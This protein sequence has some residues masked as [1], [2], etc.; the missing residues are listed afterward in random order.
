M[1]SDIAGLALGPL[2]VVEKLIIGYKISLWFQ[3]M[4]LLQIL[5]RFCDG[6]SIQIIWY[7]LVC[8]A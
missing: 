3:L 8:L 1:L 6:R 2:I 4:E 5:G 7:K